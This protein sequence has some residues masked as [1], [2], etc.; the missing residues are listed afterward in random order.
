[1]TD[2]KKQANSCVLRPLFL[3]RVQLPKIST[4]TLGIAFSDALLMSRF[5]KRGFLKLDL[6]NE[7]ITE[8]I[9]AKD[10]KK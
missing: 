9:R 2:D 3:R 8:L 7:L 6:V 1:M 4:K 10:S 5:Q